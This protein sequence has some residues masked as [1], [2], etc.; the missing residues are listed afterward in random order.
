MNEVITH[1][2]NTGTIHYN[3]LTS[4]KAAFE[5][6]KSQDMLTLKPEELP[7][8]MNALFYAS[9]KVTTRCLIKWQLYTMVRLSEAASAKWDEIDFEN[10]IWVIDG[11]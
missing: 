5:T 8:L 9:I 11:R 2:V 6:P 3:P 7:E 4:I 10:K 1:A